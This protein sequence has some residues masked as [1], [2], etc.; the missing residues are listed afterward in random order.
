MSE[1]NTVF[2]CKLRGV[3][4]DEGIGYIKP[5]AIYIW[6]RKLNIFKFCLLKVGAYSSFN[7]PYSDSR[8]HKLSIQ[9]FSAFWNPYKR[10]IF[11]IGTKLLVKLFFIVV[12]CVFVWR[13]PIYH[14]LLL[15]FSEK[16]SA[17]AYH[18]L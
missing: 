16:P 4:R 12:A 2:S 17:P 9:V 15:L 7:C 18:S 10:L 8:G 13:N 5:Y 6:L 14:S 1:I 3:K 11:I